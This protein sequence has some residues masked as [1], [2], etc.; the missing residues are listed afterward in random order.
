MKQKNCLVSVN[1]IYFNKIRQDAIL[2]PQDIKF[3]ESRDFPGW[4]IDKDFY[5]T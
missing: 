4:D 3:V 2:F 5:V 1:S